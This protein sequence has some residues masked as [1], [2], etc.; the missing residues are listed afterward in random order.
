M[1]QRLLARLRAT[2]TQSE[3]STRA[4]DVLLPLLIISI[5]LGG[6]AWRAWQLSRQM[7]HG[8]NTLAM[9][10][11]GYA[12]DVTARQLDSA[13][14]A[15]L[16]KASEEWQQLERGMAKPTDTA[17]KSWVA[18]HDWIVGAIYVPDADPTGSIF[19]RALA[20][21]KSEEGLTRE[22]YPSGGLVRYTYDPSKLLAHVRSAV[23]VQP[24]MQSSRGAQTH[25]QIDV[26]TKAPA[27]ALR[28]GDGFGF[29]AR[30]PAR[31]PRAGG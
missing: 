20:P 5:A 6:L 12:A 27:G 30:L 22:F 28:T 24:L 11:A 25:A 21:S 23:K 16:F 17:L 3:R 4:R 29:V 19:V 7:E 31:P 8:A 9:Q 14:G 18:G 2:L 10:Y 26:V 15:E 13:A 1:F